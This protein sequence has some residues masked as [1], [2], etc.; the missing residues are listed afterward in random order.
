MLTSGASDQPAKRKTCKR[1]NEPGHA[2]SLTF[3]CFKRHP[4]LSRARTR[5]WMIDAIRG[6]CKKHNIGIWAYVIMP[7]HVHLLIYPHGDSFD[8]RNVGRAL[9]DT[10]DAVCGGGSS[11]CSPIAGQAT[12]SRG[13][14]ADNIASGAAG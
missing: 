2:H 9:P 10:M 3:S 5:R 8:R 13:A 7:E 11:P 4:F 6:T 1:F 14:R 12:V